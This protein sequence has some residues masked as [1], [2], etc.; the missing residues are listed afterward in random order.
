M[1]KLTAQ[2]E[3][4]DQLC[5]EL[6]QIMRRRSELLA[7]EAKLWTAA[8][9]AFSRVKIERPVQPAYVS[10]PSIRA[11]KAYLS[12]T[13]A[14]EYLGVSPA[15]LAKWRVSGGGPQYIKLGRRVRYKRSELDDYASRRTYPHTSAYTDER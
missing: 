15:T 13:D 7:E 14:A 11:P 9:E 3:L 5:A 8:A 4:I 12:A 6:A 1:M 2:A 10:A